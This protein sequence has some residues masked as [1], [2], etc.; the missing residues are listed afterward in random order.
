MNITLDLK[1]FEFITIVQ[2]AIL[3]RESFP[4]QEEQIDRDVY[5]G[6]TAALEASK[7]LFY[8]FRLVEKIPSNMSGIV[9]ASAYVRHIYEGEP[10]ESW[11]L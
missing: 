11:M 10:A 4:V 7:D 9:A 3:A 2:T 6:N 1:T 8:A 5:S